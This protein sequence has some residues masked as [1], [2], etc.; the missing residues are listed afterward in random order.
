MIVVTW[1]DGAD[2]WGSIAFTRSGLTARVPSGASLH[3]MF[4]WDPRKWR[5]GSGRRTFAEDNQVIESLLLGP[6]AFARR[7]PFLGLA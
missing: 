2:K 1:D 7:R 3:V 4:C 5:F 6:V